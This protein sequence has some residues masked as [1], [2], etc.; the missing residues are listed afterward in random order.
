MMRKT[1][2]SDLNLGTELLH[3]ASH[4]T[5]ANLEVHMYFNWKEGQGKEG[6]EGED[7][8]E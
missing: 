4:K 3:Q 8:E 2:E 6:E 5:R 7:R 1:R